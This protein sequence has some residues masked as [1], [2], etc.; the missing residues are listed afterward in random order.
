MGAAFPFHYFKALRDE[1][2]IE[3]SRHNEA[4]ITAQAAASGDEIE[5]VDFDAEAGIGKRR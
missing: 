5:D 2:L 1:Y 3:I 4:L